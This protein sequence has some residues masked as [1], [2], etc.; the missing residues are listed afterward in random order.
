MRVQEW[1]MKVSRGGYP[2]KLF[3]VEN[4]SKKSSTFFRDSDDNVQRTEWTF[5][6]C[7]SPFWNVTWSLLPAIATSSRSIWLSLETGRKWM[8]MSSPWSINRFMENRNICMQMSVCLCLSIKRFALH[9]AM[10]LQLIILHNFNGRDFNDSFDWL[11]GNGSVQL[12]TSNAKIKDYTLSSKMYQL[13][14]LYFIQNTNES[15]NYHG[16]LHNVQRYTGRQCT[17]KSIIHPLKL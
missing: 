2:L 13:L 7:G 15:T 14:F 12:P 6:R 17:Y 10:Q 11:D 3:D 16:R 4:V 8:S 1:S 9:A 5:V